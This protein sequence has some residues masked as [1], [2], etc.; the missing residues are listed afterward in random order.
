MRASRWVW[1][2]AAL[3]ATLAC[4]ETLAVSVSP[5][6]LQLG[7]ER[8]AEVEVRG[9]DDLRGVTITVN[10]GRVGPVRPVS[11]GRFAADYT[12]PTQTFPRVAIIG[13][14]GTSAA[15]PMHGWA[16]LPLWGSAMAQVQTAPLRSVS[17]QIGARTFGP[18]QADARGACE[19]AVV[20]PPGERYA[21]FG[22]RALDLGL[23]RVGLTLLTLDRAES[24]GAEAHTQNVRL[25]AITEDGR[26]REGLKVLARAGRGAAGPFVPQSPGVYVAS[27]TVPAGEPGNVEFTTWTAAEPRAPT[28]TQLRVLAGPPASMKL[29]LEAVQWT[30]GATGEVKLKV[31]V[32]DDA[33]FPTRGLPELESSLGLVSALVDEGEG[34]WRSGLRVPDAFSGA[35]RVLVRARL[36]GAPDATAVLAL[37]AGPAAAMVVRPE[38]LTLAGEGTASAEVQVEVVDLH[39]NAAEGTVTAASSLGALEP[40]PFEGRGVRYRYRA[41]RLAQGGATDLV[42]TSGTLRAELAVTVAPAVVALT[43]APKLGF[44]TNFGNANAPT[45][46]AELM[47]WPGAHLGVGVEV[48][49]FFLPRTQQI[50]SGPLEGTR[51]SLVVLGAPCW[52]SAS[53]RTRLSNRFV[54]RATLSGG[55]TPAS[56]ELTL[57]TQQPVRETAVSPAVRLAASAGLPL[58]NGAVFIELSAGWT[59]FLGVR[60]VTG[61]LIS[62]GLGLGYRF[63]LL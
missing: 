2:M 5:G 24:P 38:Q 15:G 28:T 52:A 23:P 41:P 16:R 20:V 9:P 8:T 37:E 62:L 59:A 25:Y 44:F 53:W 10:H 21:R 14:V 27:W 7:T 36:A 57:E 30:A 42:F 35:T 46:A 22:K 39:G 6:R 43:F 34:Q 3:L 31:Q 49:A 51:A 29:T 56:S 12:V 54:F 58:T 11:P 55:V 17:L 26:P 48:G 1:L 45:I 4:A 18:V 63:D 47:F 33:G 13:V 40:I 32:D 50:G 19:V 61:P 60:N